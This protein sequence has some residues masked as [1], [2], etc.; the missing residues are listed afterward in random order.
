M[1]QET[2]TPTTALACDDGLKTAF[3]PDDQTSVLLVRQFDK[4]E[5]LIL[6]GRG[7]ADTPVAANDICLVKLNVGPG[8]SGPDDAPSTSPGIGIEVWLPL[9]ANWNNRI[10]LLGGGGWAGGAHG[11]TTQ[12]ALG[13]TYP[14][15]SAAEVAGVEGAVSASTDTGHAFIG[16]GP[17]NPAGGNGSF[18]VNPDGTIN[19]A[20]W[21]DF[22]E[23]SL[24]E[25]VLKT[26][27]LTRTFYGRD[28]RYTYWDGFS[29]GGRQALKQAQA[30]GIEFDGIL[31]G[32]PAINWTR[33]VTGE[34]YPQVVMQRDLDGVQLTAAQQRL[35]SVAAIQACD[36][37]GGVHLGYIPDPAQCRYDPTQDKA[38]LCESAG[39]TGPANACV[40]ARQA[41]AFNKI[42]YGQTPDGSVPSP[43]EDNGFAPT[44]SG[45][46][47]WYGLARGTELGVLL[48]ASPFAIAADLVA[49]E[50]GDTRI[51]T[52]AFVNAGSDGQDGWKAL[53]YAQL[54][55]AAQNGLAWQDGVFAQVNTDNP[56]LSALR[57]HGGK[58]LMYHGLADT[59][60]PAQGSTHYYERVL[61][62]M[63]GVEAVQSFY[64]FYLVPGM[65]HA[66]E[67]GTANPDATPPVPTHAE[68][69]Q[70]LTDW[71]EKGVAPE[72][73]A[74]SAGADG[75]TQSAL[76]CLYPQKAVYAEGDPLSASSY[77]CR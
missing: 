40:D 66:F 24:T 38:V 59:M 20:L 34:L 54:Y 6:S 65:S 3:R 68:L 50:L 67:N 11:S 30:N 36:V 49:M 10:H 52:P 25:T 5:P 62:Q 43:A 58:L 29:T 21:R 74:V 19:E 12:L 22:A 35:V 60:I 4:G 18:G 44:L 56:D 7:T 1:A 14:I 69:Y 57:D 48:G 16:R 37:V 27:A 53:S 31:A 28:A 9:E 47:Q 51:S 15:S 75:A 13:S 32:A 17:G 45:D 23:R 63:G 61:A 46:Q 33:F 76:L 42:W 8:N 41:Q 77:A 26:K 39:G 2:A 70:R 72:T 71:V 73:F 64:R 55:Q